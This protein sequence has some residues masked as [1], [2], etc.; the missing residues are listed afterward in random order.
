MTRD[1]NLKVSVKPH[2]CMHDALRKQAYSVCGNE[3]MSW[4]IC[5]YQATS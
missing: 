3:A 1:K 5:G 2:E 4:M